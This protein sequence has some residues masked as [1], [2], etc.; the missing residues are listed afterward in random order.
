MSFYCQ[1]NL[2]INVSLSGIVLARGRI[3]VSPVYNPRQIINSSIRM[4]PLVSRRCIYA[5]C[6]NNLIISGYMYYVYVR[7]HRRSRSDLTTF[8]R[9]TVVQMVVSFIRTLHLRKMCKVSRNVRI[10]YVLNRALYT[11]KYV[12]QS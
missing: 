5:S 11:M 2:L 8:I 12:E 9:G 1:F 10:F 4:I 6:L 3:A 7:L